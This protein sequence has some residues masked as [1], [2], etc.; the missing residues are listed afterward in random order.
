MAEIRPLAC[1]QRG[2]EMAMIEHPIGGPVIVY[3][4]GSNPEAAIEVSRW[5]RGI[6][7]TDTAKAF[8]LGGRGDIV[9]PSVVEDWVERVHRYL[10][11]GE[12]G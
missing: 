2:C 3:Q 5:D 7:Y 1:Q 4:H 6:V 11:G 8:I 12:G 10:D 9:P